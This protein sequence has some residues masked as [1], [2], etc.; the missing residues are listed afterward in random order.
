MGIE[1]T[2]R[3]R[4]DNDRAHGGGREQQ[5]GRE[6]Q[7]GIGET[8]RGGRGVRE[9]ARVGE[10]GAVARRVRFRVH[11]MRVKDIVHVSRVFARAFGRGEHVGV[12]VLEQGGG[13]RARE[14]GV[15]VCGLLG[16]REGSGER[17]KE[18]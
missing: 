1:R 13:D 18:G 2:E 15:L 6:E 4:L 11:G 10:R 9:G 12:R 8:P 17:G 7:R 14:T 3:G 16:A 5:R